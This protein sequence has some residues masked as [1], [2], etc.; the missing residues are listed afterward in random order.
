MLINL[1]RYFSTSPRHHA[2]IDAY[3]EC[4]YAS[5]TRD[6]AISVKEDEIM[7]TRE[8]YS[9]V[10]RSAEL[11]LWKG[12]AH[13]E[14]R[15]ERRGKLEFGALH[16]STHKAMFRIP[17]KSG[18]NRRQVRIYHALLLSISLALFQIFPFRRH[19][20]KESNTSHSNSMSQTSPAK[21]LTFYRTIRVTSTFSHSAKRPVTLLIGRQF[22]TEHAGKVSQKK[23]GR[24]VQW[25]QPVNSTGHRYQALRNF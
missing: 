2:T 18:V 14:I 17:R 23:S 1:W 9:S 5:S 13:G 12:R 4:G 21:F 11:D 22:S 16:L 25:Q 10:R 3:S 8:C 19:T 6:E 20:Q 7:I 15:C 24:K